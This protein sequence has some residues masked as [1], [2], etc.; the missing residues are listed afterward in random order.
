MPDH[1]PR[2]EDVMATWLGP[3]T[4]H[5]LGVRMVG[6]AT[7]LDIA[8]SLTWDRSAERFKVKI[9][10]LLEAGVKDVAINLGRVNYLDSTG[11]GVLLV[12][13]NAIRHAGGTCRF[14]AAHEHVRQALNRVHLDKVLNLF[15]DEAAALSGC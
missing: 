2:T 7:V 8:E 14:F 1:R 10:E 5:G 13:H 12:A 3:P 11:I 4:V 15:D 6:N 9:S